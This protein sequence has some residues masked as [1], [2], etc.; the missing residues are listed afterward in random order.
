MSATLTNFLKISLNLSSVLLVFHTLYSSTQTYICC[1]F[2]GG[3]LAWKLW[4]LTRQCDLESCWTW[5][6]KHIPWLYCF[7]R[8]SSDARSINLNKTLSSSDGVPH[9]NTALLNKQML[10]SEK[11]VNYHHASIGKHNLSIDW[12]IFVL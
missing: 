8:W 4:L 12:N 9:P 1:V 7:W 2:F 5:S 10:A 11:S 6:T 3:V